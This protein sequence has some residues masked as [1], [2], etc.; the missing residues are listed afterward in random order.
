MTQ[1]EIKDNYAKSIGYEDFNNLLWDCGIFE[2]EKH[3][4]KVIKL[5]AQQALE[6]A[7]ENAK[8]KESIP[9]SA[10]YDTIDKES[11]LSHDNIPEV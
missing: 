4:E 8:L 10:I 5:V 11:I 3:Y 6:N 7:A 2:I 9:H 1:Q